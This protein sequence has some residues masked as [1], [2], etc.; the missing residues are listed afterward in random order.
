MNFR[1]TLVKYTAALS[2]FFAGISMINVPAV[3]ADDV[4]STT[5][6]TNNSISDLETTNPDSD[7]KSVV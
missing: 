1:R 6:N 4:S 3:H 7:R 5:I 2:V